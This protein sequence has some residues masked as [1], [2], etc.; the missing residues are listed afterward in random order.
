MLCWWCIPIAMATF[1]KIL[2]WSCTIPP[3]CVLPLYWYYEC[4]VYLG[5]PHNPQIS[6]PFCKMKLK[7]PLAPQPWNLALLERA[8]TQAIFRYQKPPTKTP[9]Y[10]IITKNRNMIYR[11]RNRDK[12]KK[13]RGKKRNPLFSIT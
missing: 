2:D 8:I 4:L 11:Q 10:A 13:I 1:N 9:Q 5:C 3:T 6:I 7:K 12:R